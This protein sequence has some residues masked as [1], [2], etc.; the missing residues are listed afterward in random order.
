MRIRVL[1]ALVLCAGFLCSCGSDDSIANP[2]WLAGE[3]DLDLPDGLGERPS[4][5][6]LAAYEVL[7]RGRVIAPAA[8]LRL[9]GTWQGYIQCHSSFHKVALTFDAAGGAVVSVENDMQRPRRAAFNGAAYDNTPAEVTLSAQVNSVTVI[10]KAAENKLWA[11]L[12][13]DPG[14]RKQAVLHMEHLRGRRMRSVCDRGI[15][16]RIDEPLW[17]SERVGV[18]QTLSQRRPA[19][20]QTT[21]PAALTAFAAAALALPRLANREIDSAAA[22]ALPELEAALGTP[23]A[24]ASGEDLRT[25]YRTLTGSCQPTDSQ[26]RR[27]FTRFTTSLA[28]PETY[29]SIVLEPARESMLRRWSAFVEGEIARGVG[30]PSADLKAAR[31]VTRLFAF[32]S[33]ALS[34]SFK[35]VID[36]ASEEGRRGGRGDRLAGLLERAHGDF[37]RL[38]TLARNARSRGNV[39]VSIPALALDHYLRGAAH[40]YADQATTTADLDMAKVMAGWA[41]QYHAAPGQCLAK[42]AALCQ[43]IGR[44]FRPAIVAIA[45]RAADQETNTLKALEEAPESLETL[46]KLVDFASG[47]D[48]RYGLLL[49]VPSLINLKEASDRQRHLVQ[50]DQSKAL[51]AQVNTAKTSRAYKLIEA[52]YF[53]GDDIALP[54]NAPISA[55]LEDAMA[56]SQPFR[57]VAYADYFNALYNQEF[58]D[59][60]QLD[61]EALSRLRPLLNLGGEQLALYADLADALTGKAR[62]QSTAKVRLA[63]QNLSVIHA[64]MGTY[65]TEYQNRYRA[66]QAS[67]DA[68]YTITTR[69]DLVTR[70]GFGSEIQRQPGWTT[71]DSYR[72]PAKFRDQFDALFGTATENGFGQLLDAFVNDG[73]IARLRSGT[74]SVMAEHACDSPEIRQFEDG[75]LAYAKD[76]ARRMGQ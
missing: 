36:G 14:E 66:C 56:Q 18:L 57:G 10:A 37:T 3:G 35:A 53:V 63:M 47:L 70:D 28:T 71:Q 38:V 25:L 39:D 31:G 8:P 43:A 42:T 7:K 59:L 52:T 74:R 24:D 26:D 46:K 65:L 49:D 6:F 11:Q 17:L 2:P 75:L 13:F 60:R 15:V 64:V 68:V 73:N 48:A 9:G 22:L 41:K 4:G 45:Q 58:A 20:I 33:L 23:Y 69:T 12:L 61:R 54:T 76:V 67:S 34:D 1:I 50:E 30:I 55:A 40:S 27:R 21:C 29:A 51:L 19:V 62:G 16:E 5:S 72:I 32:A 44:D